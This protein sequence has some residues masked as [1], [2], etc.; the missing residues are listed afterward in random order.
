MCLGTLSITV[1]CN[2]L[3]GGWHNVS[4]E[5]PA[6]ED[7]GLLRVDRHVS[8]K[9]KIDWLCRRP[10]VQLKKPLHPETLGGRQRVSVS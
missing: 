2:R 1:R 7:V 3:L 10:D 6:Q 5:R 8:D 4:F 9:P